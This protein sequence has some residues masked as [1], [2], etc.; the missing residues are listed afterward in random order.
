MVR[1]GNDRWRTI[2]LSR[3]SFEVSRVRSVVLSPFTRT[4]HVA[5][6]LSKYHERTTRPDSPATSQV[7]ES[8]R[9]EASVRSL[10]NDRWQDSS[11]NDKKKERGREREREREKKKGEQATT[12]REYHR[13]AF[14]LN[15]SISFRS[16]YLN[17]Y[18]YLVQQSGTKFASLRSGLKLYFVVFDWQ[19]F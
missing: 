17:L 4:T 11:W 14:Y 15:C 18:I 2:T 10:R 3:R 5:R 16:F 12:C 6:H 13:S 7:H 19:I 8:A 1:N 9:P